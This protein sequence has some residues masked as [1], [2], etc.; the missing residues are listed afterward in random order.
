MRSFFSFVLFLA[1]GAVSLSAQDLP[2]RWDELLSSDWQK[3]LERSNY[4]CLLPIAVLEKHGAH[5]PIGSD[6][7]H[8][9]HRAKQAAR[10]E[11]TVVFPEYYFGQ[12]FEAKYAEGTIAYPPQLLWDLLQATLD[13]IGRNGFK[14]ILIYSTH[15]GNPHWLR[16]FIQA[17]LEKRRPYVVYYYDPKPDP[18][19]LS[20]QN[21]RR[22][23]PIAGD[24]HAGERETASMMAI[25]PDL[26]KRDRATQ[27]DGKDQARLDHLPDFWT[28]VSW[29]AR[30]PNHYAG[31][32]E[33]ATLEYG[34][35]LDE[36]GI[37]RLARAIKQVKDDTITPKV[38]EENYNRQLK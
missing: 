14:K 37:G 25:R 3:A 30:F 29:Y 11:Y 32:G 9:Q 33:A 10:R 24:E 36:Y 27:E 5:V 4:T 7:L 20:E 12:I 38:Q 1:A 19:F 15:G 35:W 2:V 18:E 8:A 16:Y 13:E 28:G 31:R 23:T 17:Q 22:K 26:V 21:K 6:L 34:K